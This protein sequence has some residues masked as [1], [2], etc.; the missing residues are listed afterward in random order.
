M[1]GRGTKQGICLNSLIYKVG[2]EFNHPNLPTS[3]SRVQ[4]LVNFWEGIKLKIISFRSEDT[5][6]EVAEKA[7]KLSTGL[8]IKEILS[9]TLMA[10]FIFVSIAGLPGCVKEKPVIPDPGKAIEEP[11]PKPKPGPE[12]KP[13]PDAV[14]ANNGSGNILN[15]GSVAFYDGWIYY[16][17][18]ENGYIPEWK[19]N[20]MRPD[21]SDKQYVGQ[22]GYNISIVDGWIYFG[23]NIQI[24]G[25]FR[26]RLDGTELTQLTDQGGCSSITVGDGWIYYTVSSDQYKL[27]RMR[28]DGSGRELLTDWCEN[29]NLVE[30][31]IYYTGL[32]DGED[33][34]GIYRIRTDG[35]DREKLRDGY[36]EFLQTDNS[37]FYFRS[38]EDNNL[39]RVSTDW[40]NAE[41][42]IAD[43]QLGPLNALNVAGN[44]IYY[45]INFQG[46]FRVRTD[47]TNL[48]QLSNDAHASVIVIVEGWIYIISDDTTFRMRL[49]GSER[50]V[51]E[52]VPEPEPKSPPLLAPKPVLEPIEEAVQ[53]V[54]YLNDY[55][56]MPVF[57]NPNDIP[58]DT[59]LTHTLWWLMVDSG[60]R[61]WVFNTADVDEAAKK[62][63]G[64]NLKELEHHE[65]ELFW[66]DAA[67]GEYEI[68]PHEKDCTGKTYIINKEATKDQFLIEVVHLR[69]DFFWN[70]DDDGHHH[71]IY[72]DNGRFLGSVS[73]DE[74]VNYD[75]ET[76][77]KLPRRRYIFTVL[78]DGSFYL[79]RSLKLR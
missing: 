2:D 15:G 49:D 40:S 50:E 19:L 47:G 41:I 45:A 71:D 62:I 51:V 53:T 13:E 28:V 60:Q 77:M 69:L 58:N 32:Y 11:G 21:G 6:I 70:D 73:G 75:Q 52:F 5:Q 34:R 78:A 46:I 23:K 54:G 35:T 72:D 33:G 7:G 74:S 61:R 39:Y 16:S 79:A 68:I 9:W 76:I 3:F 12:Q 59:L 4:G 65:I 43:Y 18:V 42:V 30:D 63:F 56:L 37:N 36:A 44:W 22:G 8:I 25:I 66:W 20:K 31:W 10:A 29:I 17:T 26:M 38:G 64:P 24:D 1:E 55:Y 27:Y 48:Q 14:S 57:S 67:R